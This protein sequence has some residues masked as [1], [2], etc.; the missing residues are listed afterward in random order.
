MSVSLLYH[1]NQVEDVQVNREEYHLDKVIFH[2]LFTPRQPLCL[3]LAIK[4]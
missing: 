2:V 1:T 4:K 3:F